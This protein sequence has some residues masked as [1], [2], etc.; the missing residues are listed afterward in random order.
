MTGR[1]SPVTGGRAKRICS[2]STADGAV[3]QTIETK[4]PFALPP[5]VANSMLYTLDQRGRITAYR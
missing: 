1:A 3:T 4:T 5:V 2:A